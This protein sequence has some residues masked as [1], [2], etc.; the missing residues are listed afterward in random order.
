[1]IKEIAKDIAEEIPTNAN[2]QRMPRG[3]KASSLIFTVEKLIR[4]SV[5]L[6]FA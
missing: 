3:E 2:R 6:R 5:S 4:D 1:M